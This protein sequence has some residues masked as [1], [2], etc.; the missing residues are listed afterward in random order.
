MA[1][2]I[3]SS[4]FHSNDWWHCLNDYSTEFLKS[5]LVPN[6]IVSEDIL[7]KY[8]VLLDVLRGLVPVP[9]AFES[10]P[11]AGITAQS[12]LDRMGWVPATYIKSKRAIHCNQVGVT[13]ENRSFEFINIPLALG[14]W[15]VLSSRRY[16]YERPNKKRKL[17]KDG[18]RLD[19]SEQCK[20]V[21]ATIRQCGQDTTGQHKMA[22]D[23]AWQCKRYYGKQEKIRQGREAQMRHF[24]SLKYLSKRFGLIREHD[25]TTVE[26]PDSP[27]L[28]VLS[29]RI[30]WL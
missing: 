5:G 8:D 1:F 10:F 25:K 28:K 19:N 6:H 20:T 12:L 26:Q 23:T 7:Y 14:G 13:G 22:K 29:T 27:D 9:P 2:W 3:N 17:R 15:V 24:Q 11:A 21:K 30:Q 4:N 16:Y 18:R